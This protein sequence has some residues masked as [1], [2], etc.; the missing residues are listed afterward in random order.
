M[1]QAAANYVLAALLA[2][3]STQAVAPSIRVAAAVEIVWRADAQ[4]QRTVEVRRIWPSIQKLSSAPAYV[5]RIT[6]ELL[7]AVLFQRP[8]PA[9]SLH[10]ELFS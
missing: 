1:A 3:L 9:P 8:P 2:L 7:S 6:A 5:S 4:Q 10:A